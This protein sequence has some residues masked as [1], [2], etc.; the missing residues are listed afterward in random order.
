MTG[1]HLKR[2]RT[3]AGWTQAKAAKTCGVSLRT[4][5]RWEAGASRVPEAVAMVMRIKSSK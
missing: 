3:K 5:A 4:W 1:T 2:L